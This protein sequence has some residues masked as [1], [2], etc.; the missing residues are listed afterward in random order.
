MTVGAFWFWQD[1]PGSP[2][3]RARPAP[4]PGRDILITVYCSGIDVKPKV[5]PYIYFLLYP[6]F[7]TSRQ[8]SKCVDP[9]TP[10]ARR[11]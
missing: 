11:D 7:I 8:K 4:D 5:K 2:S 9:V 3:A 1:K 6:H 10:L